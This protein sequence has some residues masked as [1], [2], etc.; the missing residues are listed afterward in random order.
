LFNSGKLGALDVHRYWDIQYI[1]MSKGSDYSLQRQFDDV[2][3]KY[4]ISADVKFYTTEM[5]VKKRKITE[6]EAAQGL[7]TAIWD[8][9]TVVGNKGERVSQ[10]VLVWNI[11]NLTDKDV[12]Y[13][14][15]AQLDPW[16]PTA[17]GKVLTM[18]CDLTRGME[19]TSVD[20]RG[21][22][23]S[24]LEGEG[25]KLWAW[26]NRKGW[27]SMPGTVF[28]IKQLPPG[29]EKLDVYAWSGLLKSIPITG[30][31]DVT[32]TDLPTEQSLMFVASGK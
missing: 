13:G 30:G 24:T 26:Q 5:N 8:G 25:R 18:V 31:T 4:G 22:G 17:R 21:T 12:N 28:T 10:F 32:V 7:L 27:T 1:P 23:V 29:A 15:A 9:L 6:D 11:F 3:R 2:K 14:L 16:K 20:P 19:F